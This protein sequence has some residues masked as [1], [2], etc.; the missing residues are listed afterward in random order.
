MNPTRTKEKKQTPAQ[1]RAYLKGFED[2]LRAG[3]EQGEKE[4]TIEW[5]E[6]HA[7]ALKNGNFSRANHLRSKLEAFGVEGD[8]ENLYD[9]EALKA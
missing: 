2:G 8:F 6:Q 5:E 7:T 4:I 3:K 9:P 1:K